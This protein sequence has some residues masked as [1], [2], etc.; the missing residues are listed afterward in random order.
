MIGPQGPNYSSAMSATECIRGTGIRAEGRAQRVMP[1]SPLRG[2]AR[3]GTAL[4]TAIFLRA[5]CMMLL[6]IHPDFD[7][8][9]NI[10]PPIPTRSTFSPADRNHKTAPPHRCTSFQ[11]PH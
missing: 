4:Q 5:L 1:D 7:L 2:V 9:R 11:A 6:T 8:L 10:R 3:N